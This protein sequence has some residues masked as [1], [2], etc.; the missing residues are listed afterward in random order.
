MDIG[1]IVGYP[2]NRIMHG[3]PDPTGSCRAA[4]EVLQFHQPPI[5]IS[6]AR[7]NLK[8]AAGSVF[9]KK[10]YIHCVGIFNKPNI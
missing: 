6:H 8:N 1:G 3:Y 4:P 10:L 5:I 2:H 7:P 9:K